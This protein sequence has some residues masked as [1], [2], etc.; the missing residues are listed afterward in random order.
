MKVEPEGEELLYLKVMM[1]YLVVEGEPFYLSVVVPWNS[2][3]AKE[4]LKKLY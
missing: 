2:V 3:K 4:E 1:V